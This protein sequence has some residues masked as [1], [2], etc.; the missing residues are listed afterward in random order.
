MENRK[1]QDNHT[2]EELE[3]NERLDTDCSYIRGIK[4]EM[5]TISK[6]RLEQERIEFIKNRNDDLSV[7]EHVIINAVFDFL[8]QR[9]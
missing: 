1:E 9:A 5:R 3:E 2:L 8:K 4:E 6:R 7:E